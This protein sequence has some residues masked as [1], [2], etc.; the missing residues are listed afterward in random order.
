MSGVVV[1]LAQMDSLRSTVVVTLSAI[2]MCVY[3]CT[4][5][6]V[7]VCIVICSPCYKLHAYAC[8]CT[9]IHM[10]VCVGMSGWM[11]L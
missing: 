5:V 7:G 3:I 10:C 4:V 11:C 8:G 1:V 2:V 9:C 6:V